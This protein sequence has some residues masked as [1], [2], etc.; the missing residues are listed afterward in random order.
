MAELEEVL[1]KAVDDKASDI[2]IV[3]GG[4]LSYKV[5]GEIKP[6]SGAE[7]MMPTDTARFI[8]TIYEYARRSKEMFL[9]NGDD[10]LPL[11]SWH[12]SASIHI[13]S[14]ARRRP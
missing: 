2:F 11:N 8:D 7:R 14:A 12:D 9:K 5:N 3:A 6:I 1:R 13:S 4:Y 10:D